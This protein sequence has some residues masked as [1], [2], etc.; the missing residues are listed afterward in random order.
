MLLILL[1]PTASATGD[2]ETLLDEIERLSVSASWE[3]QRKRLPELAGRIEQ[4]SPRQQT[5]F[6]L[7]RAR[8][9][10][11]ADQPER[12]IDQIAEILARHDTLDPD[13]KLRTLNLATNLLVLEGDFEQG[14]EFFRRA[15]Q[16][17]PNVENLE[18]RADTYSVAAEFYNQID[19]FATAIE[20]SD[21]ALDLAVQ[22]ESPRQQCVALERR[23][24]AHF[25]SGAL[26]DALIDYRM[27][28]DSCESESVS[29]PIFS[30]L[31]Y[32]GMG[33][34][35]HSN[36]K[37]DAGAKA[38]RIAIRLFDQ[39]RYAPGQLESRVELAD[40]LLDQSRV[41]EAEALMQQARNARLFDSSSKLSVRADAFQILTLLAE[42]RDDIVEAVEA[43]RR[44]ITLRQEH[45]NRQRSMR[46]TLLM[47][48]Q[49]IYTAER[50]LA[51][52]REQNRAIEWARESE[53]QN[54]RAITYAGSGAVVAGLLLFALLFQ[55]A[56]DRRRFR[57]LSQRDGLTG[58]LNHT[59]FFE[60]A[61]QSFQR[62]H[63]TSAPF[64]LIVADVDLFKQVNDQHGHLIGDHILR[65]IGARFQETFGP[66]AI[67]GRLG[68]EEFGVALS[69]DIDQAVARI[70]HLRAILNRRRSGEEE[71]SITMS[72]GV[73]ER[74]R[75]A[76]LDTLY[77]QADQALYDAKDS[78]RN[79][80][81]TV[82]RLELS[83]G[84]FVT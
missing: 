4:A 6:E 36:G 38:M 11:L 60:L 70:E 46:L 54:D 51:L 55:T 40:L 57:T 62:S 28:I 84:A 52:L 1:T 21:L 24:R 73:A 39:S 53:N 13:L 17:A 59:R 58:L 23:A 44:S 67:L 10:A 2:F 8:N 12:A 25:D 35:E 56:R 29:D 19:E 18:M 45:I 48:D 15:L 68:G 20:F 43:L 27:T 77:A 72:F 79:R 41:E 34:I 9:F 76:N 42:R 81:I 5:R 50:E 63:L 49:D 30:A 74:S 83:A 31:G 61:Q 69:C 78:G 66:N 7:V 3:Q 65:R 14:F 37:S 80:V 75:E 82:A 64:T 26:D 32:L 71:P 33:R 16:L 22:S 47:A